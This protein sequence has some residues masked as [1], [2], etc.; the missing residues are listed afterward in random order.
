[1]PSSAKFSGSYE[2]TTQGSALQ[3]RGDANA[4][5]KEILHEAYSQ[6]FELLKANLFAASLRF[7]SEE[8]I[9]D[10]LLL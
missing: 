10:T 2:G 1:M 7:D 5:G 6:Q 3:K 9:R 8:Y 4:A